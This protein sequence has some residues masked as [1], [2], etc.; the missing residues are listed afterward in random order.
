MTSMSPALDTALAGPNPVIFGAIEIVLPGHT[1]RLLTGSGIIV[2]ADKTF[3]GRDA[4]YGVLQSVEDLTD[5]TGDEAPALTITLAPASDAAAAG[6]ASAGM[7]G[8]QVSIWLG[9]VEPSNG[10]VVGDPLL[11]FLGALDVPT[12][13]VGAN[14]R[15][16]E[17]EITS[18]FEEFF[19]SDDGVRLNDSWHQ[20]I[21]PGETGLADTSG[22]LRQIYWGSAPPSGVSK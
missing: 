16:L 1:I 21:W 7:Q 5:G 12:L 9:V 22:V 18:V 6:L 20:S 19:T 10:L 11:I 4:T 15:L 3:T 8:S 13:K 14:S 2:F 17:L